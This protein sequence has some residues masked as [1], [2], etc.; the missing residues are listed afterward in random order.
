MSRYTMP[1]LSKFPNCCAL[2][3]RGKC[4]RLK[5]FKCEGEQCP[6]RRSKKEDEDSLLKAYKRLLALDKSVQMYIAHK[7]YDSAM[8]WKDS[9]G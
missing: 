8:P 1:D 6:F 3:E 4:T 5:L 7:Y 2:S 9:I